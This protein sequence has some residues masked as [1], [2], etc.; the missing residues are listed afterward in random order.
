MWVNIGLVV[1]IEWLVMKGC[2][3]ASVLSNGLGG[4]NQ[5]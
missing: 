3:E 5:Q 1:G 2:K 4:P